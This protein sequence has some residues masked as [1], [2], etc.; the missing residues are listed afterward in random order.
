MPAVAAAVVVLVVV[1]ALVIATR[2]SSAHDA[3]GSTA[4]LTAPSQVSGL[5]RARQAEIVRGCGR[6]WNG[7]SAVTGKV[8]NFVGLPSYGW[9]LIYTPGYTVTCELNGEGGPYNAGGGETTLADVALVDVPYQVDHDS[10]GIREDEANPGGYRVIAG[11]VSPQ[12][13]SVRITLADRVA[14]AR[15]SNGTFLICF[16][17]TD[18][19]WLHGG[20]PRIEAFTDGPTGAPVIVPSAPATPW[21]P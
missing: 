3:P 13:D 10:G 11:R 6:S 12:V 8:Y 21:H 5:S 2:S 9:A 16:N 14:S 17:Y 20:P 18:G 15:T 7:N 1:A 19:G 4:A